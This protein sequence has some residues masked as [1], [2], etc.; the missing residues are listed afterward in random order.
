MIKV[1]IVAVNVGKVGKLSVFFDP[2]T[3]PRAAWKAPVDLITSPVHF[4]LEMKISQCTR[5]RFLKLEAAIRCASRRS[6]KFKSY[7]R[8]T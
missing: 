1:E 3:L 2:W 6:R 7:A 4:E 8:G 5:G